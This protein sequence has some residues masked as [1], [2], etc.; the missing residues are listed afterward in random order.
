M[1]CSDEEKAPAQSETCRKDDAGTEAVVQLVMDLLLREV[2]KTS[3]MGYAG[4]LGTAR[5][6]DLSVAVAW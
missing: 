2:A 3:D 4:A 1:V 6:E 5:Y